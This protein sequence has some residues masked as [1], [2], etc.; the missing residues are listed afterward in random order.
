MTIRNRYP[1]D[2]QQLDS[3]RTKWQIVNLVLWKYG[4]E[5]VCHDSHREH[6]LDRL[7]SKIIKM[8]KID[9]A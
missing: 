5:T 8:T 1:L 2:I 6:E 7:I 9:K 4:R 3:S